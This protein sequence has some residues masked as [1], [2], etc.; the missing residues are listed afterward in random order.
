VYNLLDYS[1]V[2]VPVTFADKDIDLAGP[3]SEPLNPIDEANWKACS[4]EHINMK[5]KLYLMGMFR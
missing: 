4:F 3:Y 5:Q 2:T 1:A